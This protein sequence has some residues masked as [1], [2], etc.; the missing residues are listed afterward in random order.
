MGCRK[1]G[2]LQLQ[3]SKNATYAR[4]NDEL[5]VSTQAEWKCGGRNVGGLR[6]SAAHDS[7]VQ[8]QS[9][10]TNGEIYQKLPTYFIYE[11]SW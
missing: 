6:D 1:K 8:V 5:I 7:A 10:S 4:I 3:R 9:I 11:R 2:V